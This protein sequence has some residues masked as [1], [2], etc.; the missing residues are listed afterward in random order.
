MIV[1]EVDWKRVLIVIDDFVEIE[2]LCIVVFNDVYCI[3][4][5]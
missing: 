3:F 4:G 5:Y 1:V 2:V